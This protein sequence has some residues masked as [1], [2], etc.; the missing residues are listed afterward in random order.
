MLLNVSVP[1]NPSLTAARLPAA[2]AQPTLSASTPEVRTPGRR[3]P[4]GTRKISAQATRLE[5]VD[6]T[7]DPLGPLGEATPDTIATPVDEAPAPP[8]KESL[9]ARG[10][11]PPLSLSHTSSGAGLADSVNL[12]EDDGIFRGPPPVQ[13]PADVE[14]PKRQTQPSMSVEQAAKPTFD[15]NVGDPHKVG[16]LT[17]SHIVY[18]VRTKV[19]M[20]IEQVMSCRAFGA[21]GAN[22]SQPDNIESISRVRVRGQSPIP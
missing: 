14:G 21:L 17:S 13:P 15:I 3:G 18:Q 22:M 5:A 19:L 6:T 11:Q 16:D 9:A 2:P 12:E 10:P 7:V 20:P 8:L 4:R 1:V